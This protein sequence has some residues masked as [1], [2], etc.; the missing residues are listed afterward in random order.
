M[1]DQ[2]KKDGSSSCNPRYQYFNYLITVPDRTG[3]GDVEAKVVAYKFF[4]KYFPLKEGEWGRVVREP[5]KEPTEDG[6]THHFH[7][8]YCFNVKRRW[9][10]ARNRANAT[11]R[12][13]GAHYDYV[14]CRRGCKARDVFTKYFDNPSKYKRLDET[15][16]ILIPIIPPLP[17]VPLI[18]D[19]N[20]CHGQARVD[21]GN[22]FIRYMSHPGHATGK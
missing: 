20:F 9:A 12:W 6:Y 15:G 19:E 13:H 1:K 22:D 14:E 11:K 5:Y 2:T 16:G 8:G 10:S 3:L 21:W 17:P 4:D 7:I 18:S